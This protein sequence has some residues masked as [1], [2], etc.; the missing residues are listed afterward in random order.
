MVGDLV[1][2]DRLPDAV[3]LMDARA[4]QLVEGYA[5]AGYPVDAAAVLLLEFE[6]L[7][8][9]VTPG[10]TPPSGWPTANGATR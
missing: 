1:T 3:E 10:S 7:P 4:V 9:G 8:H 6:G 5:H 2:S